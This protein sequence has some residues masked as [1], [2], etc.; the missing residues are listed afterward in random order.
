MIILK[1]LSQNIKFLRKKFKLTQNELAEKLNISRQV[2]S[3]YENESREPDLNTL[4]NISKTFNCS[5]DLLLF[6][7]LSKDDLAS[8][9]ILDFNLASKENLIKSLKIKKNEIKD[10]LDKLNN[11]ID[12]LENDNTYDIDTSVSITQDNKKTN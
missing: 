9:N 7:D 3:Y 2:V 8:D 10:T 12:I 4:I 6:S 5:L 1:K 11:F